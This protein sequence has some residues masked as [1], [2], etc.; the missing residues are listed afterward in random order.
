M[1]E[2]LDRPPDGLLNLLLPNR[3][4]GCAAPGAAM[5]ARCLGAFHGPFLVR[6]RP[7]V[8][9]RG[10]PPCYALADYG[11]AARA[12]VLA[13]KERGRRDLAAPLGRL[14][15]RGLALLSTDDGD[16]VWLV[17][18]PSRRSN[19]RRRGG[20][21]MLGVARHCAAE[22]AAAGRAA[23]VAP[24]LRVRQVRDSVGLDGAQRLANLA[25]RIHVHLAGA[26]PPSSTVIVL[27]DVLTTGATAAACTQ[28]LSAAGFGVGGVLTLTVA[29]THVGK[30]HA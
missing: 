12:V 29:G 11:G 8:A 24:A 9:I 3:C 1:V 14:L 7:V 19:A 4:A 20:Q 30:D 6:R 23:A 28:A 16:T 26:P 27:D 17:P 5:C 13:Y 22:L 15:A 21:H 10:A 25:G 18:A 2:S